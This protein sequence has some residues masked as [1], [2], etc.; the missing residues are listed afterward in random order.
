MIDMGRT[1]QPTSSPNVYLIG[2]RQR[3]HASH[4]GYERFGC[5]VGATLK[6]PLNFRR[7]SGALAQLMNTVVTAVTRHPRYSLG[8]FLTEGA[9]SLHMLRHRGALYHVLYG[10]SDLLMLARASRITKNR[11]AA[12][13]HEPPSSLRRFG[14]GG[15]R[16]KDLDAVIL[17]SDSQ[18]VH[19]EGLLP[20]DRVFV[21]PHGVDTD[22]FQPPERISDQEVCIIVGG[23]LRDFETLTLAINLIWH[24]NSHV[25]FVAVGTPYTKD[26]HLR[27][28]RDERLEFLSGL[29]DE[30]LRRAYQTSRVALF[31]FRDSTVNNALLEAMACGLPIVST[32]V[33]G[34]RQYVGEEAGI[35]CPP[36]EAEGL[37]AGVLRLMDDTACA[38]RMAEAGRARAVGFH[39]RIVADQ[40]RQVYSEVL[41]GGDR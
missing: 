4:S 38:T 25:R 37:A 24:A 21:V 20:S 1:G 23:K 2:L 29:S 13:F 39:Y 33:G 17:V 27:L 9:A 14:I 11:L 31:S 5:Y 12:T 40:M 8:A 18:R 28:L 30:E 16:I 6:P 26:R 34:V 35:L 32:D 7:G 19:F 10:D 15:R 36:R 3:H 22:F 41:L